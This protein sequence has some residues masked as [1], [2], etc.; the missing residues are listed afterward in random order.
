[1]EWNGME[2]NGME[3]N[4]MEWNG[5]EWNGMEWNGM[6]WKHKEIRE[7]FQIGRTSLDEA[8]VK[9]GTYLRAHC[10]IHV[11][12]FDDA[13]ELI[14]CDDLEKNPRGKRVAERLIAQMIPEY[15]IADEPINKM[16]FEIYW[17]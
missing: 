9:L 12:A 14:G 6:E 10:A 5:M 7:D 3:W 1:M 11:L 16:L 13:A 17:I 4:G 2:W 15:N 8:I